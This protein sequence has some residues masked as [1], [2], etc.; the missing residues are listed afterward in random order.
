MSD[1][2]RA[3]I[4]CAVGPAVRHSE[5]NSRNYSERIVACC[6]LV[7]RWAGGVAGWHTEWHVVMHLAG[8]GNFEMFF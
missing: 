1:I 6:R 5:R 7:G 4:L 2:L 3:A 8:S